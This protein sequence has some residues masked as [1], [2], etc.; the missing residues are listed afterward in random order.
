S[1]LLRAAE[2]N[3][4]PVRPASDDGSAALV[5]FVARNATLVLRFDDALDDGEEARRDLTETV[6]TL[7]GYPPR[8]VFGAREIFDPNHGTLVGGAFHS[9]RV[10]VDLTVSEDESASLATPQP[11]NSVG[12]PASALA[13]PAPDAALRLPTRTDPGSG[14]F[15]LLRALGG[16][17]LATHEDGPVDPSSATVDLVR[18]LRS[19]NADDPNKGFLLDLNP[20]A[21]VGDWAASVETVADDEGGSPG[22]D[23]VVDVRFTSACRAAPR[24]GDVLSSAA[25]LLE[26]VEDGSAPDSA[27]LVRA[28]RVHVLAEE[29]VTAGTSLLGD[30]RFLSTLQPASTAPPSCWLRISPAPAELPAQGV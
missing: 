13:N 18:A 27:G 22:F 10:L 11:L 17:P 1:D 23:F 14:Q 16:A 21:I 4:A 2:R 5:S 28:V 9:T 8:L 25:E 26:L 30:A 19:G 12:L 20:P 3:L 6:R 7:V 29:P 24:R 15:E